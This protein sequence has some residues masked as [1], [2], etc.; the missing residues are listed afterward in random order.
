MPGIQKG[1]VLAVVVLC[2]LLVARTALPPLWRRLRAAEP[3]AVTL[4]GIPVL[5]AVA[6][7]L[8]FL[9]FDDEPGT[10][11]QFFWAMEETFEM[12][13]AVCALVALLQWKL[14]VRRTR[15]DQGRGEI[16][17]GENKTSTGDSHSP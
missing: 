2:V 16:R 14:H 12:G 6:Q 5:L 10:L 13:I 3:H 8:D 15:G 11:A 1:L 4:A 7:I 9:H 17:A